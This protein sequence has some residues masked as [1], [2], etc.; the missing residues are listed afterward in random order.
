V[1]PFPTRRRAAGRLPCTVVAT[2][3]VIG[4]AGC[5]SSSATGTSASAGARTVT[6][7]LLQS[8]CRPEPAFVTAG[9]TTFQVTNSGA[10]AV[11]ELEVL[12]GDRV[13]AEKENLAP[14]LSGS[15]SVTLEPG[16]Y[17]LYCPGAATEKTPLTVT[18]AASA[19]SSRS[20]SAALDKAVAD[21]QTYVRDQAAQLVVATR[22]FAAAVTAGDG[23]KAKTLFGPTRAYYE[24][25]EPV[26]ESFG[27]LDP[28]I[29]ARE[30]DVDDPA[31]WQGFHRI[32]KALWVGGSTAGI[33]PVAHKLVAD[34]EKL[35]ALVATARYQPA[36]LAN[37]A[38]ELL[39]EVGK[40]KV[41]GEE[42][43]YSHTDL[44]DFAANVE[45]AQRAYQLLAPEL[46]TKAAALA[47]TI[48]TRFTDVTL[49]LAAYRVGTGYVDYSTVGKGQRRVLAQKVDA[50]AEPLSQVSALVVT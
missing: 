12:Q 21:Y 34:V 1:T 24:R 19:S 8:G 14:G 27:D 32:E 30:N 45:G 9:A 47:A 50:L 22:G 16:E 23:A 11:S 7:T 41:T 44:F 2:A 10:A 33:S 28:D 15:F 13:L 18:S 39:D 38:S 29:D 36:Q 49:A 3:T 31:Q 20:A 6:V 48:A 40:S 17:T 26:A 43:R 5:T 46:Q 42:D 35:Q 25:I 4:L 37:G